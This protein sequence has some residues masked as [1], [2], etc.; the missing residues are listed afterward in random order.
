VADPE[1]LRI[2]RP[3]YFAQT[4]HAPDGS[5]I[6]REGA[7]RFEPNW[8]PVPTLAGFSAALDF[9]PD[10]RY[11]RAAQTAVRCRELLGSVVD[12]EPGD[13]TLV[14]FRPEGHEPAAVVK[15]LAEEGVIVREI[16]RTGLVRVSC[17]Y[18]TSDEDLERLL[19]ALARA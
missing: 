11:E 7:E 8:T 19:A 13:G 17:G 9:P 3:S 4:E 12:V 18:W 2:A 14:A 16:P 1:R 6:A 15:R 5:F 10:W